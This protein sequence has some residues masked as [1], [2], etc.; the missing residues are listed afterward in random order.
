MI[1]PEYIIGILQTHSWEGQEIVKLI[2][3]YGDIDKE[4]SHVHE[5]GYDS[6]VYLGFPAID[7]HYSMKLGTCTDW[8]G[9]PHSG[10][11]QLLLESLM[12]TTDFYDWKH[13]LCVPDI[14]GSLDI[15]IKLI[16]MATGKTFKKKYHNYIEIKHAFDTC[17]KLFQNFFILHNVDPKKTLTPIE[18]WEYATELK[19]TKG[20]H[21]ASIDSWKDMKHK[22]EDHGGGY[23]T[24]LSHVLPIRNKM[25]EMNELHFH[26]VIHPKSPQRD[27]NRKIYPPHFDDMEGGAQWG[28]SGKSIIAVHREN[29]NDN[30]TDVYFRKIKPESVGKASSTPICL[31]FDVIKSRYYRLNNDLQRV[32]ATKEKSIEP[33]SIQAPIDFSSSIHEIESDTPF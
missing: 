27:K 31:E 22:Y 24:Y 16:H 30:R 9:Y 19:K 14:G 28:A 26:T 33:V 32:Y 25:A 6:G 15:M 10:K 3:K 11:S 8:T 21:T 7:E 2:R 17:A 29:Y 4:L 20:I 12:N 18:F 13:L 5:H 1:T 23:A